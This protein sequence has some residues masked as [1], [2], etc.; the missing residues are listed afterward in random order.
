MFLYHHNLYNKHL[1]CIQLIICINKN[2]YSCQK[3]LNCI[4]VCSFFLFCRVTTSLSCHLFRACVNCLHTTCFGVHLRHM[5]C[6]TF[7]FSPYTEYFILCFVFH[8]FECLIFYLV[9]T[10]ECT[11][12]HTINALLITVLYTY[13]RCPEEY[14]KRSYNA[15]QDD[16]EG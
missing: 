4:S 1:V 12:K 11:T 3:Y 7:K 5:I 15:K 6:K 13:T 10:S 9:H 16:F 8:L 14:N 2:T